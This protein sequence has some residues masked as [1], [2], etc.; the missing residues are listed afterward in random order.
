LEEI[1]RT[2]NRQLLQLAY[3]ITG[4]WEAAA[5]VVQDVFLKLFKDETSLS[6]IQSPE[7]WLKKIVVNQALDHKRLLW[8]RLKR[9]LENWELPGGPFKSDYEEQD[10]LQHILRRLTRRERTVLVLRDVE[11]YGVD[12]IAGMLNIKESTVRVLSK[13]ARDKFAKLYREEIQ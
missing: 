10:L 6:G 13:T 7:R 9:Y 2:Y 1:Y 3:R 11:G 5:D 8:Q 12:E 4:N